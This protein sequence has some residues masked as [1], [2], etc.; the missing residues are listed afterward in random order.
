LLLKNNDIKRDV[1]GLFV[2]EVYKT[3]KESE[4]KKK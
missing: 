3:L 1:L 4:W 2:S